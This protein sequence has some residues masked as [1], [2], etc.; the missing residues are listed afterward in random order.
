MQLVLAFLLK[1]SCSVES[2]KVNNKADYGVC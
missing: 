2:K 1:C